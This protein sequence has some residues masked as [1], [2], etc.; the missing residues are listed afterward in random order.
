MLWTD[1]MWETK[2]KE[3]QKK[4]NGHTARIRTYEERAFANC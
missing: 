3:V 1:K 4:K 2:A